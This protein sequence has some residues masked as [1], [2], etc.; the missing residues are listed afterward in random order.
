LETKNASLDAIFFSPYNPK[1]GSFSCS[2]LFA[3]KFQLPSLFLQGIWQVVI[4][5]INIFIR[6][7]KTMSMSPKGL[8]NSARVSIW[9]SLQSNWFE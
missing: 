7:T 6:V 8:K 1:T 9:G 5:P 3:V 2:D 4:N